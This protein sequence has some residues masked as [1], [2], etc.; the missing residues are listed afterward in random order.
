MLAGT[1]GVVACFAL[2]YLATAFAIGYG[3]GTLHY[4]REAMLGAELVAILFLAGGVI[5]SSML[6]DRTGARPMLAIGFAGCIAAGLL[7]GPMLGAG[8]LFVLWAWLAAR[9][10]IGLVGLYLV[11]A[12]VLSLAGLALVR[13][14]T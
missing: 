6:A 3:T 2:F 1:L 5:V 4:A 12:G 13:R 11:A 9:G 7:M 8:S 14:S 10:G